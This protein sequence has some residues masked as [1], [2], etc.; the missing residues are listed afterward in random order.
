MSLNIACSVHRT[1]VVCVLSRLTIRTGKPTAVLFSGDDCLS[2]TELSS[3]AVVLWGGL[4]THGLSPIHCG[5]SIGVVFVQFMCR[6][7][8]LGQLMDVA[9]AVTVRHNL[10]GT[11]VLANLSTPAS[12]VF[13][14][15]S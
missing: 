12:S 14:E 7:S 1:V 4:R 15:E 10:T 13:L 9:S 6:Q 5:V 11:L 3:V 8:C 2:H